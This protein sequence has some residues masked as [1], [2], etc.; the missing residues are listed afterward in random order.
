MVIGF[1][2]LLQRVTTSKDHALTVLHTTGHTSRCL[3]ADV[4]LQLG[5]RTVSGLRY[6][7]LPAT[8]HN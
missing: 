7:L 2:E 8:A 5:S 1:I 6:Q 4:P 3:E